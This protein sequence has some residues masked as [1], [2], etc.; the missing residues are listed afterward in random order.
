MIR[1]ALKGRTT[2]YRYN[3]PNRHSADMDNKFNNTGTHYNVCG[4]VNVSSWQY[5]CESSF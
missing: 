3:R 5:D 4:T 2:I 1:A